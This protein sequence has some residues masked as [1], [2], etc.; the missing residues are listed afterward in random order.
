MRRWSSGHAEVVVEVAPDEPE[1]QKEGMSVFALQD[2]V[3]HHKA[4]RADESDFDEGHKGLRGLREVDDSKLSYYRLADEFLLAGRICWLGFVMARHGDLDMHSH[5]SIDYVEFTVRDL[6]V[7][8]RFYAAAFG[9][10]FT[11]YGPIYAG[12]QGSER[13]SK[14]KETGA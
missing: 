8:K 4:D 9:W 6:A 11:D 1:P 14:R 10:K 7:A 12:I 3:V 2:S 5:H 13:E